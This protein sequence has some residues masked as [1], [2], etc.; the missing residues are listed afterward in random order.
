MKLDFQWS[1]EAS[2]GHDRGDLTVDSSVSFLALGAPPASPI[3]VA[4]LTGGGDKPYAFDLATELM[5][6]GAARDLI[7]SEDLDCPEFH[8]KPG[9]NF[10]NRTWPVGGTRCETSSLH[11]IREAS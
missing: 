5:A 6:R 4:L 3:A 1:G 11:S 8:C 2:P 7:G 9:V 10:L